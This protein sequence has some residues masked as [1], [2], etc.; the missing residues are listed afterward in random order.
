[1]AATLTQDLNIAVKGP[2]AMEKW[3][4]SNVAAQTVFKGMAMV[5]SQATD[6]THPIIAD[7]YTMVTTDAFL[8]I[9]AGGAVQAIS[10]APMVNYVQVYTWPTIVGFPSA[11]FTDAA[12]GK[13]V[14]VSA[15][16]AT[17]ITLSAS[18]GAYPTIGQLLRVENGYAY[19]II[20]LWVHG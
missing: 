12:I 15:Y 6:T 18:G 8:G 19:V 1:M 14:S 3:Y 20:T 9:A 4:I 13:L 11:V 10:P 16:T 5:I 2:V 7:G 17:G